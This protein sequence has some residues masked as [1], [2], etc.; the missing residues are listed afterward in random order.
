MRDLMKMRPER[1]RIAAATNGW[2][3]QV[4]EQPD[5]S[6]RVHWQKGADRLLITEDPEQLEEP[7][8]QAV[9]AALIGCFEGTCPVCAAQ[10]S[11]PSEDE[12]AVMDR[13][14]VQLFTTLSLLDVGQSS[15]EGDVD[16]PPTFA[17][18]VWLAIE[19]AALCGARPEAIAQMRREL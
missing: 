12:A 18:E 1:L 13:R 4:F 5:G 11:S 16:R 15:L 8:R 17:V 19:H 2:S 9:T 14:R 3:R 6:R 7:L 10:G